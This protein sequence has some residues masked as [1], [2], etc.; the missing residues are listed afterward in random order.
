MA[1][2]ISDRNA[3]EEEAEEARTLYV[4]LTRARDYLVL[5]GPSDPKQTSWF[6]VIDR[7]FGVATMEHGAGFNGKTWRGVVHREL[8]EALPSATVV[9]PDADLDMDRL[10]V[11]IAPI[12]SAGAPERRMFSVSEVLNQ[13]FGDGGK[14]ERDGS[15]MGEQRRIPEEDRAGRSFAMARGTLAHRLFEE[16]DFA[17]G[18]PPDLDE[19]VKEARLGLTNRGE[20][21]IQLEAMAEH[22][23]GC[24]L[25]ARL[26]IDPGL[27]RE[28]PFVLALAGAAVRGTI[29]ALL[30]DGTI[31]DYKTGTQDASKAA[32]YAMQLALYAAA[33]RRLLGKE[34]R[35]GLLYYADHGE[36]V[37]VALDAATVESALAR[38]E[39]AVC[40]LRGIAET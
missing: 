15:E 12:V 13:V 21:K 38:A 26:A 27:K 9:T 34:P 33:V 4:A 8:P 10:R 29:D 5:M 7:V 14:E 40:E 36:A 2:A 32:R 6:G 31:I 39:Q 24:P 17:A 11:R 1:L 19:L 16:W 23:R 18:A 35:G 30:T 3:R 20:L 25:Q 37:T 28:E 22:F